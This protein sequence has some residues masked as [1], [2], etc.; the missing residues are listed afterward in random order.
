MLHSMKWS[1]PAFIILSQLT[2]PAFGGEADILDVKVTRNANGTYQFSATVQHTDTGW[3]HYADAFEVLTPDGKILATRILAHPHVNEQPFTR[4][5]SNVKIPRTIDT[6]I[7]RA[8]DKVHG[9]GG[10]TKTVT[11]QGLRMQSQ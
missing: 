7:V 5:L 8:R 2:S 4:S 10:Q 9:Y 11:I 1:L 6:V 3:D